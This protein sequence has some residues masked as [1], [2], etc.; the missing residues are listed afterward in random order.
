MESQPYWTY[1]RLN[2]AKVLILTVY[3]KITAADFK[4]LKMLSKIKETGRRLSQ[5]LGLQTDDTIA[6]LQVTSECDR[7]QNSLR[8]K[9]EKREKLRLRRNQMPVNPEQN[10]NLELMGEFSVWFL[11]LFVLITM[12]LAEIELKN[13][14]K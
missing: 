8:N 1:S 11:I 5:A 4:Q 12:I 13:L 3:K 14:A 9:A 10:E 7:I 2:I 6:L